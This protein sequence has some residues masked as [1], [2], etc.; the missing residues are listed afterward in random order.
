MR[1]VF[2]MKATGRLASAMVSVISRM[3]SLNGNISEAS[4]TITFTVLA[5]TSGTTPVMST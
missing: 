3:P 4:K 2:S 5:G 1:V